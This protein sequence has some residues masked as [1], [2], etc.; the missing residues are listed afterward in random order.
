MIDGRTLTIVS[1]VPVDHLQLRVHKHPR[2]Y[3]IQWLMTGD[4]VQVRHRCQ[5][6]F[7][8]NANYKDIVWYNVVPMDAGDTSLGRSWMYDKNGIHQMKDNTYRAYVLHLLKMEKLFHTTLR[9]W[10]NQREDRVKYYE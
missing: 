2:P 5:V 9:T 8:V 4:E 6:G 3:F 10:T 1:Q 7:T